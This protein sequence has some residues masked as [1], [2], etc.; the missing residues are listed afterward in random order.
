[1]LFA[2]F[3]YA[4]EAL[5]SVSDIV[6]SF[7]D[8]KAIS[9]FYLE[10]NR[11]LE[12]L[13]LVETF[14]EPGSLVLDIGAQPFTTS[15][16]LKRMGYKAVAFDVEPEPYINTHTLYVRSRKTWIEQLLSKINEIKTELRDYSNNFREAF[17]RDTLAGEHKGI[18]W[19]LLWKF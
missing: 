17:D 13:K 6:K 1:M 19:K 7:G 16:A 9:S 12:T 10:F 8:Q 11:R 4:R 2:K 18:I 5:L 14:C 3:L 15:C